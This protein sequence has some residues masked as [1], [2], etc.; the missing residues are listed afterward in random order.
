MN[1]ILKHFI[2]IVSIVIIPSY[3]AITGKNDSITSIV[4]GGIA[5]SFFMNLNKFTKFKAS[6]DGIEAELKEVID[7]AYATIDDL[8]KISKNMIRFH[9]WMLTNAGRYGGLDFVGKHEVKE[10]LES[11]TKHIGIENEQDIIE[12]MNEF[13]GIH[14][15]DILDIIRQ[16][17]INKYGRDKESIAW[18][19]VAHGAEENEEATSPEKLREIYSEFANI[20]E[21]FYKLADDYEKYLKDGK[22]TNKDIWKRKSEM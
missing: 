12:A 17:L 20:D 16:K 19:I 1:E 11:V 22:I 15:I 9:L 5:I 7:K 21:I 10:E 14:Q 6:S 8:K 18:K 4:F 13:K 2:S 3:L